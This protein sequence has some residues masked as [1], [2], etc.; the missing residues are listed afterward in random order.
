MVS[1]MTTVDAQCLIAHLIA[2]DREAALPGYWRHSAGGD[3]TWRFA[4]DADTFTWD[5]EAVAEAAKQWLKLGE[6]PP[7]AVAPAIAAHTRLLELCRVAGRP[8]PDAVYHDLGQDEVTAVWNDHKQVVI[9]EAVG[10][11]RPAPCS[12]G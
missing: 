7:P 10:G 5:P 4:P 8:A 11:P 12:R 1:T 3:L 2:S 6:P 9:V